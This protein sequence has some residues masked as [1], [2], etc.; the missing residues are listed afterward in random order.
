MKLGARGGFKKLEKCVS[1]TGINGKWH[2]LENQKQFFTSD[3][4][5]LNWSKSGGTVWFQGQRPAI[6]KLKRAFV[7]A[8]TKKG[9]LEGEHDP[10]DKTT[11][12]PGVIFEIAKIKRQQKR[13]RVDAAELKKQQNRMRIHIA[14]LREA[15]SRN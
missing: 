3:G 15:V 12:P 4:A 8:A 10:D 1:K 5:V 9:L 14:E 6:P 11:D 7:T 13:M 2:D